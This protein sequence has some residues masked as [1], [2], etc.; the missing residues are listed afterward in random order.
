M[1]SGTIFDKRVTRLVDG[2]K[3]K[4]IFLSDS[5]MNLKLQPTPQVTEPQWIC[6]AEFDFKH[7]YYQRCVSCLISFH[8][9]T[10]RRAVYTFRFQATLR[11]LLPLLIGNKGHCQ[12]YKHLNSTVTLIWLFIVHYFVAMQWVSRII[13]IIITQISTR[14]NVWDPSIVCHTK[15]TKQ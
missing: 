6:S 14:E 1:Q 13:I 2:G 12:L 3:I 5:E 9:T 8:Y 7:N 4:L 10:T 15:W 11:N